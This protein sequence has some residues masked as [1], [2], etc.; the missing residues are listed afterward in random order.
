MPRCIDFL[1]VVGQLMQVGH[2]LQRYATVTRNEITKFGKNDS[3]LYIV[4][5]MIEPHIYLT[6][7]AHR[8]S[9]GRYGVRASL[10]IG[11][12][13]DPLAFWTLCENWG[14]EDDTVCIRCLADC[15]N[16][17][18]PKADVPLHE[19]RLTELADV[20]AAWM[21]DQFKQTPGFTKRT[22]LT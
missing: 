4:D 14:P 12:E 7:E 11:A 10:V 5:V 13:Q 8:L 18:C 1:E 15:D 3:M 22:A 2:N 20:L 16:E 19:V 21:R 6:L 9:F 17:T